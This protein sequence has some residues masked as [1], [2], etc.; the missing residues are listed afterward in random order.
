MRS[1]SPRPQARPHARCCRRS[2]WSLIRLPLTLLPRKFFYLWASDAD[3]VTFARAINL[4]VFQDQFQY[5]IPGL[6]WVTQFYWAAIALMVAGAVLTRPLRYWSSFPANIFPILIVYWTA[7]HMAFFGMGRFH[8][9]VIQV[10]VVIAVHLLSKGRDWLAWVRQF[11]H[12][13]SKARSPRGS[14][15]TPADPRTT[16]SPPHTLSTPCCQRLC[17][18]LPGR[19]PVG[20]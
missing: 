5:W 3:W 4:S 6:K 2:R 16:C 17:L 1:R 12:R 9:Q 14:R 13:D 7:F 10:I 15:T 20:V 18:S 11:Q 8:A 19:S